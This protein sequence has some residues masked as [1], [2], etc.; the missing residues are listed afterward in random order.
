VVGDYR[1][2][3]EI[4]NNPK[5]MEALHKSDQDIGSSSQLIVILAHEFFG[6]SSPNFVPFIIDVYKLAYP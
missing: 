3:F 6:R 2:S 1:G 5:T 4:L